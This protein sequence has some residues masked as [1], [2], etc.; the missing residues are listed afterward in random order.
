KNVSKFNKY[1]WSTY[2]SFAG[3][4]LLNV[5]QLFDHKDVGR[6]KHS[7]LEYRRLA[8]LTSFHGFLSFWLLQDVIDHNF[9]NY[10]PLHFITPIR[11]LGVEAHRGLHFI[12]YDVR[13]YSFVSCYQTSLNSDMLN[14][15]TSPFDRVSWALLVTCFSTVVLILTAVLSNCG[16]ISSDRIFLV[17]GLTLESSVLVSRTIYE[18]RF[19]RNRHESVG[20]YTIIA[21]WILLV[22]TVLTN[23]Y[24]SCF[25][26][27]MIVPRTYHSPWTSVTDVE[28]VRILVP[29]NL[30]DEYDSEMVPPVEYFRYQ[31]FYSKL[32][33]RCMH[34]SQENVT[35]KRLVTH[36]NTAK[37]WF[38]L[39]LPHFGLDENMN[40]VRDGIFSSYVGNP[41]PY[42]KS[43][44]QDYPIQPIEYTHGDTFGIIKSLS[45]CGKIALMDSKENVAAMTNFLNDNKKKIAYVSGDDEFF[46]E[47]RG[48]TMF[49]VRHSYAEERLKHG[50]RSHYSTTTA[51]IKLTT[52]IYGAMDQRLYTGGLFIDFQSAFNKVIHVLLIRKLKKMGFE[53]N[54]LKLLESYLDDR[55]IRVKVN[56]AISKP[57][58]L[59][60]GI[61]QGGGISSILFVVF[62]NDLPPYLKKTLVIIYADDVIIDCFHKS[63]KVIQDILNED[64]QAIE[65]WPIKNGMEINWSKTHSMLLHAPEMQRTDDLH[66]SIMGHTVQRVNFFKYLGLVLDEQLAFDDHYDQTCRTVTSSIHLISRHKR[67]FSPKKLV[68][69]SKSLILCVIEYCIP[70]WGDVVSCNDRAEIASL[71]YTEERKIL[72]GVT[73]LFQHISDV[74]RIRQL[75]YNCHK[76]Y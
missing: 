14:T 22:G 76:P 37:K 35:Y 53:G 66:I 65:E 67:S 28:G 24:K 59:R 8:N 49:P 13:T 39:L 48:W 70:V 12:M 21:V 33:Y 20:L 38:N 51:T 4:N 26:I 60:V 75:F 27:E 2:S 5:R 31:D 16:E 32:Y 61:P 44:L 71:L 46:T 47:I 74:T 6:I 34:T 63:P 19:L 15:L 43:A 62:I 10:M 50:F 69:F 41:L 68:I 64:L 25:T 17:V 18:A 52:D 56:G 45:S 72:Y 1:Y 54:A 73:F 9:T 40:R 36:K 23:W 3:A 42:N 7:T 57:E 55:R 11:R 30:L 58:R 29:F